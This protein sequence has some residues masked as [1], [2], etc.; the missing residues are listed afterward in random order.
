MAVPSW[1]LALC[2]D[3]QARAGLCL[4]LHRDRLRLASL[5]TGL[6]DLSHHHL[7]EPVL[8]ALGAKHRAPELVG[9]GSGTAVWTSIDMSARVGALVVKEPHIICSGSFVNHPL[10]FCD[11]LTDLLFVDALP[12]G[13]Q[14]ESLLELTQDDPTVTSGH[15]LCKD[16]ICINQGQTIVHQLAV[17]AQFDE[18]LPIHVGLVGAVSLKGILYCAVFATQLLGDLLLAQAH[19]ARSL[20][21]FRRRVLGI[22]WGVWHWRA[23]AGLAL[24]RL[25]TQ[26]C[27]PCQCTFSLPARIRPSL[28]M[29]PRVEALVVIEPH[30][31]GFGAVEYGPSTTPYCAPDLLQSQGLLVCDHLQ[32]CIELLQPDPTVPLLA[33]LRKDDVHICLAKVLL[34]QGRI[35]AKLC[36]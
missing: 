14:S 23:G 12:F 15:H 7:G 32:G 36:K 30:C 18:A 9:A 21:K 29:S 20:L 11:T 6:T 16:K 19:G 31:F 5:R 4:G 33:D 1:R 13:N 24:R 26:S 22:P 2:S 34:D 10:G 35:L 17:F 28:R 8:L 25:V 27:G 3:R